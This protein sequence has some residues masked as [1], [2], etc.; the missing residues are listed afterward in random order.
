MPWSPPSGFPAQ[1]IA[2]LPYHDQ[3]L[4]L[5]VDGDAH[6]EDARR[7]PGLEGG[8]G[9]HGVEGVAGIDRLEKA[10]RLLEKGDE[11][12]A[13]HVGE[14]AGARRPCATTSRPWARRSRWPCARQ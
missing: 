5:V 7:A 2:V 1:E 4:V 11:R 6:R 10:R 13:H 9:E 14:D 8:D 3:L 12:V